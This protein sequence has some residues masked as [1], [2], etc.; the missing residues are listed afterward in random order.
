MKAN[1]LAP[2]WGGVQG[3]L[4]TLYTILGKSALLLERDKEKEQARGSRAASEDR[5]NSSSNTNRK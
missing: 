5:D 4:S 1:Q 2:S 3:H